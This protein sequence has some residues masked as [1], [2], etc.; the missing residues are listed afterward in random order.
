ML[1]FLKFCGRNELKNID[2]RLYVKL[3]RK[4]MDQ[5]HLIRGGRPL[6][7]D[8]EFCYTHVEVTHH[9]QT[10]IASPLAEAIGRVCA[11]FGINF[12]QHS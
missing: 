5:R 10:Q 7:Q 11:R 4:I 8:K 1:Q 12:P 2:K 3:N 9:I 6:H